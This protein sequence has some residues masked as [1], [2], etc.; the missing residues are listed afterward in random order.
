MKALKEKNPA[1]ALRKLIRTRGIGSVEKSPS[2]STTSGGEPFG[3]SITLLIQ[4][5][6]A[7]IFEVDLF[8]TIKE[9]HF[10]RSNI[11]DLLQQLKGQYFFRS[12][13]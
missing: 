4:R 10:V 1:G 9:N 11:K 8:K 12:Y 2:S 6:K 7:N 13:C 5:L 3:N